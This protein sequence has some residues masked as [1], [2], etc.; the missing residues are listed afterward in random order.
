[1]LSRNISIHDCNEFI[2]PSYTAHDYYNS[3]GTPVSFSRRTRKRKLDVI[4]SSDSEDDDFNKQP[5]LVS[6]K[7]LNHELFIEEDCGLLSHHPHMRNCIRPLTDELFCSKV[8]KYEDKDILGGTCSITAEASH[9]EE[10]S[11]NECDEA[12]SSGHALMDE[13]GRM[14]FNRRSFS[15]GKFKNQDSSE[16]LIIPSENS[17]AFSWCDEELQMANTVSQHGFCLYAKEIDAIGSNMGFEHRVDLSQEMLASSTSAMA[18][19]RLLGHDA[20]ASWTSVDGKGL[21]EP[22]KTDVKSYL[23]NIIRSIVPS[24]LYLALR[25]AA[26]HEY[27]SSLGCISRSEAS[28][29]SIGMGF[30]KRQDTRCL[31]LLEFCALMLCPEDI[32]F[33]GQYNFNG[34]LSSN[35]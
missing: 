11:Q 13:C 21:D 22:I 10:N 3:S 6:D 27:I 2:N 32:S 17:D 20:R 7:N 18:L 16:L 12:V 1:M 28:C 23:F 8:E 9:E 26:F 5:S 19:G 14:N 31:A 33:L 35:S 34:K 24:R 15:M 30:T 25:G 29:L 4:M